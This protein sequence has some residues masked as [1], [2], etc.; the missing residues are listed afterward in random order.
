MLGY[1]AHDPKRSF[2]LLLDLK[3][4]TNLWLDAREGKIS[5]P[6]KKRLGELV[7]KLSE[8]L[9]ILPFRGRL[10]KH[11]LIRRPKLLPEWAGIPDAVDKILTMLTEYLTYICDNTVWQNISQAPSAIEDYINKKPGEET[12]G[13]MFEIIVRRWLREVV[14]GYWINVQNLVVPI[15]PKMVAI[16]KFGTDKPE[17]KTWHLIEID[18]ISLTRFNDQH[19]AA[20]AE[21]KW[22]PNILGDGSI[23][24]LNG[25]Y[26]DDL[27]STKLRE[28]IENFNKWLGA[29]INYAEVALISGHP[30]NN[31][32]A[33]TA[34]LS[35]KLSEKGI[36][37][38]DVKLYDINDMYKSVRN[39]THQLKELIEHILTA[40]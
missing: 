30:V 14:K 34:V 32:D 21:I 16:P 37:Y 35:K 28:L 26:V 38:K 20:V 27:L 18:A 2:E 24:D 12:N 22:R 7:V 17:K 13:L 15:K 36:K 31:R 39:S 11:I 40:T 19:M 1:Y 6:E 3:E 23:L 10:L 29:D 5:G 9:G 4:F 8:E 25:R 33:A